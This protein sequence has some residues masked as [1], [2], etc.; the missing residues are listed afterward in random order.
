MFVDDPMAE[1]YDKYGRYCPKETYVYQVS[2]IS[3][4]EEMMAKN[5]RLNLFHR[6]DK[7]S[8]LQQLRHMNLKPNFFG[9]RVWQSW[10]AVKQR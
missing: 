7:R 3:T 9:G 5:E 1:E 8:Q 2:A 4:F 6:G 10:K